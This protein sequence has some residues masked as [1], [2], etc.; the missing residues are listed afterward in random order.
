LLSGLKTSILVGLGVRDGYLRKTDWDRVVWRE[1]FREGKLSVS[2][3]FDSR[4]FAR[5]SF[6]KMG[7]LLISSSIFAMCDFMIPTFSSVSAMASKE[8]ANAFSLEND[9]PDKSPPAIPLLS[10]AFRCSSPSVSA[11]SLFARGNRGNL[12]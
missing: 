6:C 12:R 9:V 7:T 4:S 1:R 5:N 8:Q 3:L 11:L 10:G 2:P